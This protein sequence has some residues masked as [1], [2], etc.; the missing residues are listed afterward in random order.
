MTYQDSNIE[1]LPKP[2]VHNFIDLEGQVF[3]RLTVLGIVGRIA[4]LRVNIWLCRCQCGKLT[5]VRAQQLRTGSTKSCGCW[6]SDVTAQRNTTHGMSH[7][8]E[9]KIW[10]GM[11]KRCRSNPNRPNDFHNYAERGITICDRWDDFRLFLED[12]GSRPTPKHSIE[13]R[14]NDGNYE[15]DNCYWGNPIQQANNKRTSR[16][17]TAFNKSQTLAQW[18]KETKIPVAR[19]SARLKRGW[20]VEKSITEPLHI[21]RYA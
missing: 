3:H 16:I 7:L 4:R 11:R 10:E 1:F 6:N 19:I 2:T 8:S 5:Q 14:D 12:M 17:L 15:P 9:Y 20:S 13:R 21:N 18:S